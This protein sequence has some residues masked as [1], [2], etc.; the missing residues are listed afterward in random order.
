MGTA[1]QGPFLLGL[2]MLGHTE[3]FGEHLE[4][5]HLKVLTALSVICFAFMSLPFSLIQN[6]AATCKSWQG[7]LDKE[8]LDLTGTNNIVDGQKE[9]CGTRTLSS[10]GACLQTCQGSTMS[11]TLPGMR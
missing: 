11:Q 8:S 6:E 2:L 9:G 5:Q 4:K 3:G 10:C 1:S 7:Y